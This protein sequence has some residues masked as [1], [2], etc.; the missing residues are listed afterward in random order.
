M[1]MW[2]AISEGA[3]AAKV[4][5][6]ISEKIGIPLSSVSPELKDATRDICVTYKKRGYSVEQAAD[7]LVRSV[8]DIFVG[9]SNVVAEKKS[10]ELNN[11][12]NW[13]DAT[14]SRL[15]DQ[16]PFLSVLY[17]KVRPGMLALKNFRDGLNA[18]SAKR[19]ERMLSA[20]Y[21]GVVEAEVRKNA[22]MSLI[23][24][25]RGIQLVVLIAGFSE[26]QEGLICDEKQ[27]GEAEAHYLDVLGD[28]SLIWFKKSGMFWAASS[29]DRAGS[30]WRDFED[31]VLSSLQSTG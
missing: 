2:S 15:S 22:D 23:D 8:G 3:Y 20:F 31:K 14:V 30:T 9:A 27:L 16:L 28:E 4:L 21:L 5:R 12:G 13:K 1:G 24:D 19:A 7:A 10:L 17:N 11:Y 6:K 29:G 26:I 25:N 18:S